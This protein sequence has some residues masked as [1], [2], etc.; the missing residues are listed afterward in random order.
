MKK[1]VSTAVVASII[2]AIA[3]PAFAADPA[4]PTTKADCKK[5]PDMKWD[6]KTHACVKK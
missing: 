6:A 4:P 1:S 5:M 2:L 3:A